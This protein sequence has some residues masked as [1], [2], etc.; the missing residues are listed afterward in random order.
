MAKSVEL[1]KVFI[2]SPSD[3]SEERKVAKNVIDELNK[4]ICESY[5]KILKPILWEEDTYPSVGEYPQAVINEQIQDYDIFV[6]IMANRFG[7]PTPNAGS[8]TEEEFNIAYEK[9]SK[10]NKIQIMFFFKTVFVDPNTLGSFESEQLNQIIKVQKFKERISKT[11]GVYYKTFSVDFEKEFRNSLTLYILKGVIARTQSDEFPKAS[12]LII[13]F[14]TYL[15]SIKPLYEK[16]CTV[17]V[18]AFPNAQ[19]KLKDVYVGQTLKRENRYGEIIET[20]LIDRLPVELIKKHKKVL[21]TDTAGMGKSTI[22]KYMLFDLIYYKKSDI[23]IPIYIELNKLNSQKSTLQAVNDEMKVFPQKIEND[24][25]LKLIQ[26]G[27][28]VFFLDGYDEIPLS[29]KNIVVQ[30]IRTFI[31]NAGTDNY[32]IMASRPEENLSGF[33]D[34]KSFSIQSLKQKE[35]FELLRRYDYTNDKLLSQKL[36][37]LLSSGRYDSIKEYLGNPLLVSLLFAAFDYKQEIPLKKHLFY[38]QVYEAFFERHDESKLIEV[39]KKR[40]GLD[41]YEF[42]EVLNCIGYTCL[43]KTGVKFNE[44]TAIQIIKNAKTHCKNLNFKET[45]FLHDLLLSVPLFCKDGNDYKWVH[46]S[47]MEYFAASFIVSNTSKHGDYIKDIFK[48]ENNISNSI[49]LLDLCYDI[50]PKR[51]SKSITLPFLKEYV[52]YYNKNYP[53]TPGFDKDLLEE[54][55]GLLYFFEKIGI[56]RKEFRKAYYF[57]NETDPFISSLGPLAMRVHGE[58]DSYFGIGQYASERLVISEFICNKQPELFKRYQTKRK[59]PVKQHFFCMNKFYE[60]N[61]LTGIDDVDL[62]ILINDILLNMLIG[63]SEYSDIVTG[64]L[65]SYFDYEKATEEISRIERNCDNNNPLL[66]GL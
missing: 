10:D 8:G 63:V 1:I 51:F 20:T 52:H 18:L 45:H 44:D 62:F 42:K 64:G 50:D 6:G 19:L 26:N 55:I 38:K 7:S 27:G 4:T 40:S 35:A 36:I 15:H 61:V 31:F 56:K 28:F 14:E 53:K 17:N 58:V 11:K 54:R 39:H 24:A 22:L 46:K 34:F 25:L 9:R 48:E 33:G 32:Y 12:Q 37:E 43:T 66:Y 47:L 29:D 30:D 2:S 21:I 57:G 49:N 41:K 5:G 23:G 16:C 59:R 13:D 60:I 65:C 3:V